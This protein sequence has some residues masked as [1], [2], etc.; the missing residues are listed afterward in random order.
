MSAAFAMYS[1]LTNF[2]AANKFATKIALA[3][4]VHDGSLTS[5]QPV[6]LAALFFVLA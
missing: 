2:A 1:P 5:L 3:T 6:T 4:K